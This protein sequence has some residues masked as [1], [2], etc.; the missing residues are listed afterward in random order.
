MPNKILGLAAKDIF[1]YLTI[2]INIL[3]FVRILLKMINFARYIN[4]QPTHET[5]HKTSTKED[6]KPDNSLFWIMCGYI[7]ALI[8]LKT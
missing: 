7:I 1:F 8:I 2:V 6:R 3:L 4:G 5:W